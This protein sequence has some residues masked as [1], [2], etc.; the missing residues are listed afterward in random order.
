MTPVDLAIQGA[1]YGMF[2][3]LGLRDT[4]AF[5]RALLIASAPL[6]YTVISELIK[7]FWINNLTP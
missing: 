5:G 3:E 7:V 2:V 1:T 4:L 6:L